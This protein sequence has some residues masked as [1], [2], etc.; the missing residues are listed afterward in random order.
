MILHGMNHQAK[1]LFYLA[2][3]L[4]VVQWGSAQSQL[5]SGTVKDERGYPI[6]FATIMIKKS[7]SGVSADTAGFF[8]IH[9]KPNAQL[10]IRA[11]GFEEIVVNV[12]SRSTLSIVLKM[13]SKNIL[14]HDR[15]GPIS[16]YA[17]PLAWIE[18]PRFRINLKPWHLNVQI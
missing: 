4:S 1:S 8:R 10:L 18:F 3:L 13:S 7:H 6:P 16:R 17:E 12:Q 5:V 11:I 2:L 9:V 14:E 15:G